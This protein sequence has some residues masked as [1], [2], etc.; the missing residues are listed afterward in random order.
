MYQSSVDQVDYLMS[1]FPST[2][3]GCGSRS[4]FRLTTTSLT[5]GQLDAWEPGGPQGLDA[6]QTRP[7]S[8]ST[9]PGRL[10]R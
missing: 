8:I 4:P 7:D 2:P 5:E 10:P 6:A 1:L 9:R 3:A